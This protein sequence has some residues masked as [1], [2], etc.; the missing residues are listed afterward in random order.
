MEAAMSTHDNLGT[1]TGS[2]G[3]DNKLGHIEQRGID[4]IPLGNQR[5]RPVELFWTWL[6]AN[7][8]VGYMVLGAIVVYSGLSFAQ[9]LIALAIGNLAFFTVGVTSLQGPQARTS[10]FVISRASYGPNGNR[11]L[12][13]FNWVTLV[14]FEAS[15]IALIALA[16]RAILAQAGID[17]SATAVTS[18][19]IVVALAIQLAVPLLPRHHPGRTADPELHLHP[20]LRRD[21]DPGRTK[22]APGLD[23]RHRRPGAD[24]GRSCHR[25]LRRGPVVVELRQRLHPLPA[26]LDQQE[27][28]LLVV[29]ARRAGIGGQPGGAGCSCGLD[30]QERFRPD[31]RPADGAALGPAGPVPRA[32]HFHLVVGQRPGPV[33]FRAEPPGPGGIAAARLLRDHRPGDFRGAGGHH[34]VLCQV[35]RLLLRL[36][37]AA[38]LVAGTMVCDLYGGLAAAAGLRLQLANRS[39]RRGIPAHQRRSPAR[40]RRAAAGDGRRRPVD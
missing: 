6:A 15:S 17:S 36:P 31:R 2:A 28:H 25:G 1:G 10:T 21:R 33:F 38:D 37:R 29:V 3:A 35:Q 5:G 14:G 19:I 27:G 40:C 30:Y 12:A 32:G 8:S 7:S 11:L 39:G 16:G 34:R 23:P 18:L 24:H 26:G 9:A 20:R 13:F 22:G 4:L